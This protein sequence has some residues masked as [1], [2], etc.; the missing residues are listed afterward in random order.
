MFINTVDFNSLVNNSEP[1]QIV[2]FINSTVNIYD[3]IV[4]TYDKVHKIETK[5]DGSYMVVAGI[6][7]ESAGSLSA[8][9][10]ISSGLQVR[11][12]FTFSKLWLLKY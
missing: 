7:S 1:G 8:F 12:V 6:D 2:N 9:S 10:M 4:A 3:K 5:A 11:L